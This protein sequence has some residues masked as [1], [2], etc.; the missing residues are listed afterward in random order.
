MPSRPTLFAMRRSLAW[1]TATLTLVAVA[2][3]VALRPVPLPAAPPPIRL[4]GEVVVS[5]PLDGSL[6]VV[7]P[8]TLWLGEDRSPGAPPVDSTTVTSF[9]SP[10]TVESVGT[11]SFD[12]LDSPD[13]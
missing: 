2:G 3:V 5:G 8:G 11:D 13:D 12:S 6:Q 7:P 1:I 4:E 10:E 9:D